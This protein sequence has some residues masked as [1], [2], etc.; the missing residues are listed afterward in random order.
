LS[1]AEEYRR[2]GVEVV[3][4]RV[5]SE[6]PRFTVDYAELFAEAAGGKLHSA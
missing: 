6:Q 5:G 1:I 3:V 2:L 4:Y